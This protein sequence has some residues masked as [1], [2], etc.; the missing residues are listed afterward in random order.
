M[1]IEPL[2]LWW[3]TEA[4]GRRATLSCWIDLVKLY[5][6]LAS[7]PSCCRAG[8]HCSAAS[9]S[10]ASGSCS[11]HHQLTIFTF[12]ATHAVLLG[13]SW[14]RC[15]RHCGTCSTAAE[16]R[17]PPPDLRAA[18]WAPSARPTYYWPLT[19]AASAATAGPA[20]HFMVAAAAARARTGWVSMV[21]TMTTT[22]ANALRTATA[23]TRCRWRGRPSRWVQGAVGWGRGK[24]G[25]ERRRLA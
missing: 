13:T 2:G 10:S 5:L 1:T 11:S 4:E 14:Q 9:S 8:R 17:V 25:W 24:G 3:A 22:L 23:F 6:L 21:W 19:A 20:L 15:M 7:T 18:L 12:T 16:H